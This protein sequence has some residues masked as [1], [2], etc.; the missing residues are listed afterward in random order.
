MGPLAVTVYMKET[1]NT[2][3]PKCHFSS[4]MKGT[5]SLHHLQNL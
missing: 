3:K 2:P 1:E 5:K 4:A